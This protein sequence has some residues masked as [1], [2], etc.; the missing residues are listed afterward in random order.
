MKR[1]TPIR[2]PFNERK[3]AAAASYL[4]RLAGGTMPYLELIKLMY[5]ADRE[6][7]DLYGQPITGDRYVNMKDGPVLSS[8]YD[9]IKHTIF[10]AKPPRGP[11]GTIISK[12]GRWELRL[13][14]EPDVT[15][16]S[17]AEIAL[18]KDVFDTRRQRDRW[19]TRDA[20]HALPEWEKPDKSTSTPLP[21]EQ[22]LAVLGKSADE[23]AVVRAR[24]AERAHFDKIFGS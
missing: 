3:A 16:L 1:Q 20:S 15:P 7:L 9:L 8:V 14:G 13:T 4:L 24:A 5:F 12:K 18:L 17:A 2:F 6:S 19:E 10:G 22:I 23:I 11:W 21:V